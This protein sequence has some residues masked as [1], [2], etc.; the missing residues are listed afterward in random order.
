MDIKRGDTVLKTLGV[1]TSMYENGMDVF[2]M[3]KE[4]ID[5]DLTDSAA[6][7]SKKLTDSGK[8]DTSKRGVEQHLF[9]LTIEPE[10]TKSVKVDSC[11]GESVKLKGEFE[12]RYGDGRV[13]TVPNTNKYIKVRVYGDVRRGNG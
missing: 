3:A 10:D 5:N 12:L 7:I 13:V 8:T 4:C 1:P 11:C 6:V 2:F 9:N